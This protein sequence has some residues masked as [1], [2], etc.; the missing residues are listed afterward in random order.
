M[1]NKLLL[2]VIAK[3]HKAYNCAYEGKKQSTIR[4]T[5]NYIMAA[6]AERLV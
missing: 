5:Y 2:E 4:H 3:L 6:L 1:N